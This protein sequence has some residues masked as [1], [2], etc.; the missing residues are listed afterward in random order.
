[1][2]TRVTAVEYVRPMQSGRTSPVLVRCARDDDFLIEVVVKFSD[3]CDQREEN[4]AMEFTAACLA[5]DLRLPIPEPLLVVISD[6]WA[7]NVPDQVRRSRILASSRIAF[8]SKLTQ[9]EDEI[10]TDHRSEGIEKRYQAATPSPARTAPAV[11]R[12]CAVQAG[13]NRS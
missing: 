9:I 13:I 7:A 10:R 1:M 3:Y 4:L 2:L 6:N 12:S 8:G 5:G 11:A